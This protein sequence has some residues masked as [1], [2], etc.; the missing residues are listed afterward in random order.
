[1][2][3][4]KNHEKGIGHPGGAALGADR[5]LWGG[6]QASPVDNS[7]AQAES[8]AAASSGNSDLDIV[9]PKADGFTDV[10]MG[11]TTDSGTPHMLTLQIPT[12][13]I[14]VAGTRD[15]E[16]DGENINGAD[17]VVVST[18][19]E[20]GGFEEDGKIP[21][22]V[23]LTAQGNTDAFYVLTIYP[24]TKFSIESEKSYEPNGVEIT[25]DPA[26]PAYAY[27]MAAGG[28]YDRSLAYE[29]SADWTLLVSYRGDVDG[30]SVEEWAN[31]FYNT[32]EPK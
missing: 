13:Y 25:T 26:H 18:V 7:S 12:N 9:Y 19:V 8:S 15:E 23:V 22:Q 3:K 16:G 29:I 6:D 28:D 20:N 24:S 27:D 32:I 11:P 2:Y 31:A 30:S 21:T 5:V 17:G 1:M 4:E 10:P 14:V